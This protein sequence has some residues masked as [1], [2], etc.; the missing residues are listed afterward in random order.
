MAELYSFLKA[1]C[2][3]GAADGV[4]VNFETWGCLQPKWL[5]IFSGYTNSVFSVGAP[6]LLKVPPVSR[7]TTRCASV[8]HRGLGGSPVPAVVVV[9]V[10]LVLKSTGPAWSALTR[11]VQ[12]ILSYF[13]GTSGKQT[14][15]HFKDA[16]MKQLGCI[17]LFPL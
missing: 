5:F 17:K 12:F 7:G 8:A 15:H 13:P 3:L 6:K 11:A 16:S 14:M 2:M 10:R 1:Q 9:E 4:S